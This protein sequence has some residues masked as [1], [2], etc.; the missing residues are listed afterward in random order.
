M[1]GAIGTLYAILRCRRVTA[2]S[3]WQEKKE[4]IFHET[5]HKMQN[6]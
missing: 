1:I 4:G 6:R 2:A 3:T 5:I